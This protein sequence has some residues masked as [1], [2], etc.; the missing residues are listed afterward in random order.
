M[1][2]DVRVIPIHEFLRTDVH[3]VLDPG[4]SRKLLEALIQA[5]AHH[6]V[7]RVLLDGR[8]A[9]SDASTA[10]IWV[11]ASELGEL[12]MSREHRI[13]FLLGP[14]RDDFDRGAF[15]ELCA[16]NRGFQIRAFRDFEEAFSW[17][18]TGPE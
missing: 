10:D 12:G 5:A 18:T 7:T 17:L 3:G 2:Y 16:T 13:A 9:R 1:A 8:E 4:S 14:P 11:L 6:H 15:L